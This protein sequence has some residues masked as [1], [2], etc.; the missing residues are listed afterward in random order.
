MTRIFPDTENTLYYNGDKYSELTA[1]EIRNLPENVY[2]YVA[3][4]DSSGQIE[5][6]DIYVTGLRYN[7]PVLYKEPFRNIYINIGTF[8]NRMYLQ[9][10]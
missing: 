10:F 7:R 3:D 6:V 4:L 5:H 2:I 1:N 9:K 8:R